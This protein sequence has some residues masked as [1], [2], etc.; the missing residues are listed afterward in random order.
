MKT[1]SIIC[2]YFTGELFLCTSTL[3]FFRK[4]ENNKDTVNL[5][6]VDVIM[7]DMSANSGFSLVWIKEQ[8]EIE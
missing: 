6:D 1:R 7:M 3:I 8:V 2:S 4:E 5:F